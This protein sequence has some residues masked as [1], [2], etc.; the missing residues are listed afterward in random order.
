LKEGDG[1]MSCGV[2]TAVVREMEISRER[3]RSRLETELNEFWFHV[4]VVIAY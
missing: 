1:G 3:E 4:T 2:E